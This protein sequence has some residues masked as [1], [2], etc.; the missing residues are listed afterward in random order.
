MRPLWEKG[1]K[2]SHTGRGKNAA[3]ILKKVGCTFRPEVS[4][5]VGR[6]TRLAVYI[7]MGRIERKG[8]AKMEKTSSTGAFDSREFE[9]MVK[10]YRVTLLDHIH[11]HI[12][13]DADVNDI[14]QETLFTAYRKWDQYIEQGKRINWLFAI[15][16]N[17][18]LVWQRKNLPLREMEV[19]IE[20]NKE[21]LEQL[22]SAEDDRGLEEILTRS[23]TPDER[24]A[25][26]YFYQKRYLISEIAHELGVSQDAIKKRLERGR[27]HL[28]KDLRYGQSGL[29]LVL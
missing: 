17:C 20:E 11:D 14:Y 9:E 3:K 19:S 12:F 15:S 23:V 5:I 8:S 16:N 21:I 26:I 29:H 6:Q 4:P 22:L 27:K 10:K 28:R 2:S 7:F 1:L 25:L 24:V 13:N 18:I